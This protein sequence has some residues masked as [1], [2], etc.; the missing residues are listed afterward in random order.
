MFFVMTNYC[1]E[2]RVDLSAYIPFINLV[3]REVLRFIALSFF[4]TFIY[5]TTLVTT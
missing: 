1:F 4:L 2:P 5:L 3:P